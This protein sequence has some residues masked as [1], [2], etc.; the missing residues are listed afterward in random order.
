MSDNDEITGII[1]SGGLSRRMG[2]HKAFMKI[3][4]KTL[5]QLVK[6]KSVNQV[7][8]L[9]LN[10]NEE[11]EKRLDSAQG[12]LKRYHNWKSDSCSILPP[13]PEMVRDCRDLKQG[14]RSGVERF[15]NGCI[16]AP[17]NMGSDSCTENGIIFKTLFRKVIPKPCYFSKHCF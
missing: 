1:L 8:H 7:N 4:D 14:K 2:Q 15:G 6:D 12:L 16:S 17:S 9:I 11:I 5:I 10:S 13:P 3:N